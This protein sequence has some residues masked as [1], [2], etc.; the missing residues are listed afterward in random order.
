MAAQYKEFFSQP[1]GHG[2]LV[3]RAY[4]DQKVRSAWQRLNIYSRLT[5]TVPNDVVIRIP[6]THDNTSLFPNLPDSEIMAL[7]Q[8]KIHVFMVACMSEAS[9]TSDWRRLND[10]RRKLTSLIEM[11]STLE[12]VE[13][14]MPEASQLRPENLTKSLREMTR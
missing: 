11:A 7:L 9:R 4:R 6:Q 3:S 13:E 5:V 14:F 8:C 10:W 1:Q 2:Q 12:E